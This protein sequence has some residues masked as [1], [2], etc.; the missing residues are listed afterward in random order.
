MMRYDGWNEKLRYET[1]ADRKKFMTECMP[2]YS[3]R[4]FRPAQSTNL[5]ILPTD[6][7]VV[8]QFVVAVKVLRMAFEIV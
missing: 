2:V 6:F 8:G 4:E 1:L 3:T 7:A 5:K